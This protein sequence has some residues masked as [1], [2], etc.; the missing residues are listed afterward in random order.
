LLAVGVGWVGGAQ[1]CTFAEA[2]EFYSFRRDGITGRQLS[3]IY[4]KP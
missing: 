4:I 2:D 1:R 3:L